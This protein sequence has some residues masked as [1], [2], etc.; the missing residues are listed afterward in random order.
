M[1][2]AMNRLTGRLGDYSRE[3]SWTLF[4]VIVSALFMSHGYDKLLG[5][6]AQ[7]FTGRGMT[8]L[9]IGDLI[10]Y[11]VP[12][13]INLLFVAGVIQMVA[14]FSVLVGLWTHIMAFICFL[15][16]I[17]AYVIMHPAWF[18]TMNG[19]ELAAM[20]MLSYMV[21]FAGGAGTYS[22]DTFLEERKLGKIQKKIDKVS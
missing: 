3:L 14:G 19:G 17:M 6:N 9:Q 20:Y 10:S 22:M 13:G 7:Q 12:M 8:T 4:R 18:P 11:P 16:M 5:S 2:G 15:L 1:L 21:I